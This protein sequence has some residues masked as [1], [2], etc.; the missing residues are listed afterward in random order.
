MV[1]AITKFAAAVTA[2]GEMT[3]AEALDFAQDTYRQLRVCGFSEAEAVQSLED[4][5]LQYAD[6]GAA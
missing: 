4:E 3:E 5:A 2:S 6:M 1:E